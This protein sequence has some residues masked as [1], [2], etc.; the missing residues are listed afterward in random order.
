MVSKNYASKT[1]MWLLLVTDAMTFAG[2]L[3]AYGVYRVMHQW[4]S[5]KEHLGIA[6]SSLATFIL[7][8]SSV[9]MVFSIDACKNKDKDNMLFWLLITILGGCI[10]L[11][12]QAYEYTHLIHN[13]MTFTQFTQGVPLFSTTF[14]LITGFHGLHV[15]IGT[16]YLLVLYILGFQGSCDNGRYEALEVAGLFWHFV[17]LVWILVFTFIYLL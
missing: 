4:P 1:A 15:F 10:F 12:I 16:I 7:I 17:D 3:I 5:P 6:L 2:F 11:G 9:S 8:C 14:F 13:G